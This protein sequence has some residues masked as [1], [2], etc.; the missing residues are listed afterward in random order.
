MAT[1]TQ[2]GARVHGVPMSDAHDWSDPRY[3]AFMMLRIGFAALPIV[4]GLDKFFN[5]LVDWS[6]YPA[7]M[8]QPN[9]PGQRA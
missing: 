8:S 4:F 3:Q 7:S 1:T 9:H 6:Q 2:P 5:A